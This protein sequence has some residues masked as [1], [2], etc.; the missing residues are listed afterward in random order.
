M[1]ILRLTVLAITLSLMACGGDGPT[2]ELDLPPGQSFCYHFVIDGL[3]DNLMVEIQGDKLTGMG[4]RLY[5]PLSEIYDVTLKGEMNGNMAQVEFTA[6]SARNNQSYTKREKW[7]FLDQKIVIHNRD[8]HNIKGKFEQYQINCESATDSTYSNELYDSFGGFFEGYA[9]VGK[10]GL[11]GLINEQ[12]EEVFPPQYIELSNVNENSMTYYDTM[13]QRYGIIDTDN[14]II[15]EP[16]FDETHPFND[17]LAAVLDG[18]FWGFMNKEGEVVI[19]PKYRQI[20]IF[21][22]EPSRHPFNEG[23]A[24]VAIDQKWSYIN[25]SGQT[26]IPPSY[27]YAEGFKNGKARVNDG[28]KFF[29]IDKTG[30]CVQDCE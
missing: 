4:K 21:S 24:N 3:Q 26:V 28:V 7:E 29:Y 23:L 1:N 11:Y 8:V 16:Q 5:Q 17:G 27:I 15:I 25:T 19:G 2:A 18:G 20:N 14:K 12:W 22:A 13:T 6:I 10:K 30:K 9:V